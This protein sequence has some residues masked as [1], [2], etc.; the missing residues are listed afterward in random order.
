MIIDF[1]VWERSRMLLFMQTIWKIR[2]SIEFRELP[3]YSIFLS[4]F[5]WEHHGFLRNHDVQLCNFH[6]ERIEI[7]YLKL[8]NPT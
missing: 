6:I 2:H 3:I 5:S 1:T 4:P 8:K 7:T